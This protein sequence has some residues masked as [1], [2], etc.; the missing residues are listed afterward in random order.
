MPE[1]I[2]SSLQVYI[3]AARLPE[4]ENNGVS[5]LKIPVDRFWRT[6]DHLCNLNITFA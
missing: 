4:P 5:C 6:G 2:P 1:L 3:R